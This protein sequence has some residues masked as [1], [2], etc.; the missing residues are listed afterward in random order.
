MQ[1]DVRHLFVG[2]K[3]GLEE[4]DVPDF[5]TPAGQVVLYNWMKEDY[6]KFTFDLGGVIATEPEKLLNVVYEFLKEM[7]P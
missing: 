6:P 2:K 5:T 7:E 1:R 4:S 3:L